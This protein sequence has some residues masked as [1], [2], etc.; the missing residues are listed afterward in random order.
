MHRVLSVVLVLLLMVE[1]Q[2]ILR[3]VFYGQG[4]REVPY[5]T[6]IYFARSV[7][8]GYLL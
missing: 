6:S 7:A 8:D 1:S 3:Y 4:A 5:S 2:H